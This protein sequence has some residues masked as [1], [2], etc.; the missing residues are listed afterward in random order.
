MRAVLCKEYGPPESLVVE[1]VEARGPAEG[2]VRIG[3]HAC[4]VNFPDTL[5]IKGEYQ[6]KPEMPFS[7]GGEVA[8]E[9]L[10]TGSGVTGWKAGDRVIA[11]TGWGGFAEEVNIDAG[12]I[13]PL[14]DGMDYV[15]G[16]GFPM[17]YGTALYALKQRGELAEGENLLVYGASGGVGLAAVEL[18]K[19]MG[20]RVIAAASTDDK[21]TVAHE[22]GADELI[23]YTTEGRIRDKVK[24]VT[25]DVIYDPVGGDAFDEALRCINWYGRLLVIGFASGRIPQAPANLILLK[26]CQVVG[27]FWG[28]WTAR[29]PKE[30]ARNFGQLFQ[31]HG[32]G[33]LRPHVSKTYSLD[34][35]PE[36]LNDMLERRVTGKAVLVTGR[37]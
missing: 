3:V 33:R 17:T 31:W 34:Q 28:A 14:P 18:G 32:E 22:H 21:L 24:A 23:N 30:N 27:I 29:E 6:F 20:A 4:G 12:R 36:A 5:I 16:A 9:I 1:D 19:I 11:M 26:S 7:P 13:M 35:A 2:E 37:S 8:G 15:T 10:E 25:E